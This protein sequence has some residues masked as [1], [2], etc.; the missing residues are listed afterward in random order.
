M[1]QTDPGPAAEE[2]AKRL[3]SAFIERYA[4]LPVPFFTRGAPTRVADPTL[5]A[6]NSALAAELGLD[7]HGIDPRAL[8]E[9]FSGNRAVPGSLPIAMAY[10]GHQFGQF[11]PQ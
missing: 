3:G 4:R 9:I 10:A 8:A 6:F 2:G 1:L 7:V 5:I 11:V